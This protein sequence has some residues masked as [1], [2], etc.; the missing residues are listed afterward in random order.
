MF[1][2]KRILT[3]FI[4]MGLFS[5]VYQIGAI[6]TVNEE[7]AAM[8][9][10]E[11]SNLVDGIDGFG[12]FI[13]N[14]TI[15]LPMFIPGFGLVWGL[16]A[17]WS[18]G[19]AFAAIVT[20]IPALSNFPPLAVLYLSPFGIM[21]LVAYSLGISRSY[22]IIYSFIK[23]RSI[24]PQILTIT[25]EIGIVTVLLLIGGYLEYAMIDFTKDMVPVTG[26]V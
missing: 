15:A 24:K 13:H 9:L 16:F 21:E 10:D 4:F 14:L 19:F 2:K 22:I 18:T 6:S 8:F 12:I 1:N 20:S 17:G 23:H 11:F 26:V 25:I 5:A 7:E 3:F